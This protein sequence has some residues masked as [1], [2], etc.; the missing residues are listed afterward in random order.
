MNAPVYEPGPYSE[1]TENG[2]RQFSDWYST[3]M[4]QR[5]RAEQLIDVA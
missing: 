4:Q 1:V 2:V 5:L 3:R